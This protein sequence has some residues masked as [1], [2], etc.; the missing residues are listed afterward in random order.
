MSRGRRVQA[1]VSI[2]YILLFFA[3]IWPVYPRFATI[4]PRVLS[5]PFSLA[6]V[7]GG[8][9]LSFFVLLAVYF[10]DEARGANRPIEDDD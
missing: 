7:V 5:V 6:Y 2:F 8:L 1:G 9:L 4:E 10:W 3:L